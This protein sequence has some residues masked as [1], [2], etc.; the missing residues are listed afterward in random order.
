MKIFKNKKNLKME[1]TKVKSISFIPTMGG[2]HKGHISLIKRSKK[3]NSKI[4]VSIF[5]NPK[6][7][8]NKIDYIK[9]PRNLKNDLIILKK[10]KV[11]YVYLPNKN[12]IFNFIPEKK[13]FLDKFSKKLC[14][15][16]R[17]GHFE[18]V[19]NIVNRFLQIIKPKYLFLGYKDFQQ[20][21]LID[22]HLL[23]RKINTKIIR[24]KTIREKNGI[25]YSSR[26]KRLSKNQKKIASNVYNYIKNKK[27]LYEFSKQK[28]KK[29]ILN[30]GVDK[31]DYLEFIN[32]DNLKYPINKNKKFNIFIAFYL[33]KVRLIDNV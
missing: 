11:N 27:K 17:V 23:K 22:K 2:L 15:K 7:F 5:V 3:F 30:L 31:I 14:G 25:P 6:Q 33:G 8:N 29:F 32:L 21:Y 12:D 4:L 18:G 13:I 10:L 16:T 19:V 1:I 26:N 20:L 9:Y 24:C 28:I